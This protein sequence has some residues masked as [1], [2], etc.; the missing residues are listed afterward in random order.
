MVLID[1]VGLFIFASSVCVCV[2][3]LMINITIFHFG[4]FPGLYRI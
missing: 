2:F 3:G 4:F 1:E